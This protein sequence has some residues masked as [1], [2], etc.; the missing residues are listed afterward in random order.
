MD[1]RYLLL[2]GRD[3]DHLAERVNKAIESGYEP[4]G[5]P[6]MLE[7]DLESRPALTQ[8]VIRPWQEGDKIPFGHAT[9]HVS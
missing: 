7:I 4:L 5:A 9:T 2:C 3:L 1:P 6:C 8:A